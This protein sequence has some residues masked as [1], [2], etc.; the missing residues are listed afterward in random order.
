MNRSQVRRTHEFS[1][2]AG[3]SRTREMLRGEEKRFLHAARER[4]EGDPR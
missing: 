2:A 4:G 1:Q 3:A